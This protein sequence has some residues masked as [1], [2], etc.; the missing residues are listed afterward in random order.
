[1]F[2][3]EKDVHRVYRSFQEEIIDFEYIVESEVL[4]STG[5]YRKCFL[6]NGIRF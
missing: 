5:Y 4:S 6:D 1:M 3:I 2:R